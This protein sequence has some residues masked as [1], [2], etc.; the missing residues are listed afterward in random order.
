MKIVDASLWRYRTRLTEPVEIRPGTVLE[1]RESLLLSLHAED[2]RVG[3]GEAAPLPGFSRET[4][5]EVAVAA[6]R[7]VRYIAETRPTVSPAGL[8]EIET[9]D[10]IFDLPSLQFALSTAAESLVGHK[11][12][13]ERAVPVSRLLQGATSDI[14]T[15]AAD[16]VRRGFRALKLKVG[17]RSVEEDIRLLRAVAGAFD[18]GVELRVDANRSW[19]WSQALRFAEGVRDVCVAYVEEPLQDVDRLA[20]LADTWDLPIALDESVHDIMS[21]STWSIPAYAEAII[22]KPTLVG[23]R[24]RALVEAARGQG[25]RTILSACYE[26]GL[27]TAAVVRAAM[28]TGSPV[29]AVGVGTIAWLSADCLHPAVDFLVP[30]IRPDLVSSESVQPDVQ[31]LTPFLSA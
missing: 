18:G 23:H 30:L 28:Q 26:T 12:G 22:V 6:A 20:E 21:A 4:F 31:R 2:G 14:P 25:V 19:S 7:L 9:G 10:S 16:Y 29:P 13:D 1:T 27:G 5:D 15:R 8:T 11:H 24:M 3:W 17:R